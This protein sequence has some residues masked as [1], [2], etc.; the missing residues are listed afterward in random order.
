[1]IPFYFCIFFTT[2]LHKKEFSLNGLADDPA[3][4]NILRNHRNKVK[5]LS[6]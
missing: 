5:S 2:D 3:F 6:S 1:M 4:K